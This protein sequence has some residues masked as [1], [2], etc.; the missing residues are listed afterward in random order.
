MSI[1]ETHRNLTE[2]LRAAASERVKPGAILISP[3][4]I[5]ANQD[6]LD[7]GLEDCGCAF[8]PDEPDDQKRF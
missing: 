1:E 6:S 3:W 2:I 8:A 4:Q 5:D 7:K